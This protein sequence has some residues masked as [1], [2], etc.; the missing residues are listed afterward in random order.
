MDNSDSITGCKKYHEIEKVP[1][2]ST[3]NNI[4]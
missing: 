2:N 4:L 3:P 1:F